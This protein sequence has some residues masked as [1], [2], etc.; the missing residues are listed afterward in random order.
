MSDIS[1]TQDQPK[2]R[3]LHGA[4]DI[5]RKKKIRCDS[6]EMPGKCS[7]CVFFKTQCTHLSG[8]KDSSSVHYQNARE[9][10]AAIL[11]QTTAYVPSDDP[12]V[13]Y[14]VLVDIAKYARTLEDLLAVSSTA[15]MNLLPSLSAPANQPIDSVDGEVDVSNDGVLV[16]PDIID[17]LRGLALRVP[18]SG[19]AD[20]NSRYF[21]KS[22]V[23][24]FI[25][26]VMDYAGEAYMFDAQRPEFWTIHPWQR[27]VPEAPPPQ[28]F[29]D[30]DLLQSLI[31]LYFQKI[32][33]LSFVLHAPSFR[34]AIANGEHLRDHQ[35]GAVVL[36]VCAVASRLS[37]D[38]RVLMSADSPSNSAGWKWFN[39]ARPLELAVSQLPN[40]RPLYKLQ[41]ICLSVLFLGGTT[42]PRS[43][44]LLSAIGLRIAHEMGAH[45]RSRY[46]TG[47]KVEGE[48]LKRAF[49][50]LTASDTILNAVFGRPTVATMED[51]DV[52]LPTE[53]D[54]EYWDESYGFRQPKDK[55]ALAAY[56]NSH[57]KLLMIYNRAYHAI[58]IVKRQK[59]RD[60]AIVAELDAALNK[61]AESIPSHLRW[62]PNLEGA[63]LDQSTSLF[64]N[65]YH[66][67]MMIHRPFIPTP[68]EAPSAD[69]T[70]PSLAICANSARSCSHVMEVHYKRTGDILHYPHA[71]TM[72]FDSSL[73][74]L[75]NVW[76]GRRER[77]SPSDAARAAADIKKCVDV[78]HLY[79]KRY[80]TAGRHCDLI[81]E[82]LN[83][84]SG[85]TVRT[86]HPG[87]KR[88]MAEEAHRDGVVNVPPRAATPTAVEQLEQ[89][90]LSIQETDHLFSLPLYTQ[91]LGLLP[92]YEPFDFQYNYNEHQ[93]PSHPDAGL[94]FSQLDGVFGMGAEQFGH[95][96]N[97]NTTDT[98][99][100]LDWG[101]YAGGSYQ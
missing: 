69:S 68:G 75:L 40:S 50:L 86:A 16:D 24:N 58:Y 52:E 38:S 48:L 42:T 34:A 49:W 59:G 1:K 84:G 65:Y 98:D 100:W 82:I 21:G 91:E 3:R 66:V 90:Q 15:L 78:L 25:K 62:D 27:I 72:L 70:F 47:S 77:L 101:S 81:T 43:A 67:Q 89:L 53:C 61:W 71:A 73:I 88:P 13:L 96:D 18:I 64:M 11:S 74:L 85:N 94:D 54:D 35:F 80:P 32:H 29:P 30:D 44:W 37:D 56:L 10:V 33:P 2:R 41:L 93:A 17:P 55:P 6:S 5:C 31:D 51:L 8:S 45:R 46:S 26:S 23:L 76:G 99:P 36:V 20:E 39:Q 7:N 57:L 19:P 28:S 63:F 95:G 97:F 87:L 12:T 60:A 14:R 92:V 4:C 9:H 79:E 83:R 22:S